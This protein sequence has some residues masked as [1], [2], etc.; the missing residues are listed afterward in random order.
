MDEQ[1]TPEVATLSG[2]G[3]RRRSLF[4]RLLDLPSPLHA[5]GVKRDI[6][7]VMLDGVRLFSDHYYPKA[8]GEFPIDSG[9]SVK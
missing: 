2:I 3:L 4:S 1:S 9:N 6:P 7:V 8:A 5:V